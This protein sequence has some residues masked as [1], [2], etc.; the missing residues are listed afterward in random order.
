MWSGAR[1]EVAGDPGK[2]LVLTIEVRVR[3][4]LRLYLSSLALVAAITGLTPDPA[5]V[6]AWVQRG[7][8]LRVRQV[9]GVLVA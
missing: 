7:I 9:R 3:W 6:Q 2:P 5:K 4:W 8:T 1:A